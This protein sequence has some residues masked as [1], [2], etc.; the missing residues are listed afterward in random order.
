MIWK[1]VCSFEIDRIGS[2]DSMISQRERHEKEIFWELA[3]DIAL[4]DI[5]YGQDKGTLA[6]VFRRFFRI[7]PKTIDELTAEE[8][9]E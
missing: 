1:Y 2:V 4:T 3:E 6:G 8:I 7:K 5:T 9:N